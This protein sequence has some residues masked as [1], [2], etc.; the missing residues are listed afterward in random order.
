VRKNFGYEITNLGDLEDNPDAK[1][2]N[3]ASGGDNMLCPADK[4]YN[5]AT[6][7][8][9]WYWVNQDNFSKYSSYGM[10]KDA[11]GQFNGE[12]PKFT[13]L[14]YPSQTII[15]ADSSS[16]YVEHRSPEYE[17]DPDPSKPS[18]PLLRSSRHGNF[19]NITFVDGHV[20]A[21]T[22]KQVYS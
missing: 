18:I 5:N 22:V 10:N 21:K 19:A 16:V 7:T 8:T 15:L 17:I 1:S 4:E 3:E 9:D 11:F 12:G 2:D 14:R 6:P 20:K 13:Q